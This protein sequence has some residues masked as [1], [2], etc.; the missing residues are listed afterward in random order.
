MP[1]G[2]LD[3]KGGLAKLIKP[4]TSSCEAISG[5]LYGGLYGGSDDRE[6]DENG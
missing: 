4:S 2:L 5:S 1:V 3:G 6:T